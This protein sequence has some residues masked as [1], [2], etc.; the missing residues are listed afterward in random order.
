MERF[1]PRRIPAA[2]TLTLLPA[3]AGLMM[4]GLCAHAALPKVEITGVTGGAHWIWVE[5]ENSSAQADGLVQYKWDGD[6]YHNDLKTSGFFDPNRENYPNTAWMRFVE[7]VA[8]SIEW[9]LHIPAA[10]SAPRILA[11]FWS[12]GG[13]PDQPGGT[14]TLDGDLIGTYSEGGG[15][16][17]SD[18]QAPIAAG[19][20]T[21]RLEQ[22][23]KYAEPYLDGILLYDGDIA[24]SG[25][26][27]PVWLTTW[28]GQGW[29]QANHANSA[30]PLAG[31]VTPQFKVSGALET[32]YYMSKD[33]S[34]AEDFTPGTKLTDPGTYRVWAVC[35]ASD[36]PQQR[37]MAGVDFKIAPQGQ[38]P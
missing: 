16:V 24:P 21:L 34:P 25:A 23:Y 32:S 9:E 4:S 6:G 13:G 15:W 26:P 18:I 30:P 35:H 20:H 8:P 5:A 28:S 19:D 10:M 38:Q 14:V 17:G 1:V 29:M 3:L 31:P 36:G 12:N 27:T 22:N 11:N 2:T 7:P 33:D 37:I